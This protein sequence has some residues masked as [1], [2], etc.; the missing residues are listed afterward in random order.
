MMS[1]LQVLG[2]RHSGS[3]EQQRFVSQDRIAASS[4]RT[5]GYC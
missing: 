4:T 2:A 5:R 3:G 1:P